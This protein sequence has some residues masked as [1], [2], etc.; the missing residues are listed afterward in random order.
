MKR[1]NSLVCKSLVY[2]VIYYFAFLQPNCKF[3]A[4]VEVNYVCW[5]CLC[6]FARS[7]HS[8][9]FKVVIPKKSHL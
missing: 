7:C 4:M 6:I 9:S 2:R 3:I 1:L 8:L 5:V